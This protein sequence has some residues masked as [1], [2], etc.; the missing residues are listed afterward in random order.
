MGSELGE[1]AEACTSSRETESKACFT[2]GCD[3]CRQDV[4]S[5]EATVFCSQFSERLCNDCDTL[6]KKLKATR[7]HLVLSLAKPGQ[8]VSTHYH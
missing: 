3:A 6:H 2:Y 8:E 7:S 1:M 5:K 4:L